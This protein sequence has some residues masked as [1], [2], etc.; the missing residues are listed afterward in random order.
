M[1]IAGIDPDGLRH[2]FNGKSAGFW[3]MF[4]T[5]SGGAL[6]RF[7]VFALGV[8]P[9]IS[10]SILVQLSTHLV[11]MIERLKSEGEFGRR[12]LNI[13]TRYITVGLA[14]FQGFGLALVLGNSDGSVV[15]DPGPYFYF[16]TALSLMGGTLFLVW[17]GEQITERGIGNGISILVFSGIASTF[18]LSVGHI[19]ELMHSGALSVSS[20]FLL[21]V[22]LLGL[23]AFLVFVENGARKI[24]INHL[25]RPSVTRKNLASPSSHLPLKLNL[26]GV[27]PPIFASSIIFLPASVI[28][29]FDEAKKTGLVRDSLDFLRPGSASYFILYAILILFFSFFYT[30]LVVNSRETADSLKKVGAFIPGIRPGEQTANYI[31]RIVLRLTLIGGAY[32]GMVCIFPE[33]LSSVYGLPAGV[34]GTSLLIIV[35]VAIDFVSQLRSSLFSHKYAALAKKS[36]LFK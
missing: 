31:E 22:L 28:S 21:T 16:I 10:S 35:L 5:F 11:P 3:G 27:I 25:G 24:L 2:F 1:P 13:Y 7:T 17:L 15:L 8:I 30:S 9:Y 32:M 23:I 29:Y 19:F 14:F 34:A 26:A 33:I 18:P 12:R 4:N 36:F 6:S 20:F